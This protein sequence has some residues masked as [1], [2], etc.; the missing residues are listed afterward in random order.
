MG[1]LITLLIHHTAFHFM[2][3]FPRICLCHKARYWALYIPHSLLRIVSGIVPDC[4][5]DG[6][7]LRSHR[8]DFP[9][10]VWVFTRTCF[11]CE[12]RHNVSS[13]FGAALVTVPLRLR[14]VAM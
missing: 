12:N 7:R 8:R 14:Y 5:N 13:V 2:A 10:F 1:L 11:V 4:G 3:N 9:L 6:P